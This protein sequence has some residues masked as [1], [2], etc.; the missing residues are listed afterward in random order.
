ML[1]L[2]QNVTNWGWEGVESEDPESSQLIDAARPFCWS[3]VHL[4]H[5]HWSQWVK[6][7]GPELHVW[8]KPLLHAWHLTGTVLECRAAK[9]LVH[10]SLEFLA[11]ARDM[12]W[13]KSEFNDG[14][15][16]RAGKVSCWLDECP[17]GKECRWQCQM[18]VENMCALVVPLGFTKPLQV[19]LRWQTLAQEGYSQC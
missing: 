15:M 7:F 13:F 9:H 14:G 19:A 6:A 16:G 8:W 1:S 4:S 12:L 10:F 3:L 11:S 5:F 17:F 2:F 18:Q